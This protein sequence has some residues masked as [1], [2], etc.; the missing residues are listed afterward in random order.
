MRTFILNAKNLVPA[1]IPG[2]LGKGQQ[3]A[4]ALTTFFQ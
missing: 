3:V 4:T 1:D 2:A